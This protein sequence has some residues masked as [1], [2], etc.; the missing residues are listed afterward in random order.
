MCNPWDSQGNGKCSFHFY[1]SFSLTFFI[2]NVS[3]ISKECKTKK[4]FEIMLHVGR[5]TSLQS[6]K[7]SQK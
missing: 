1:C 3:I 7:G 5:V 4:Q 2:R 6:W